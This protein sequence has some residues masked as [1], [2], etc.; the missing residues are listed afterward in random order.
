M[1][2]V[3]TPFSSTGVSEIFCTH[4]DAVRHVAEDRVLAIEA[5]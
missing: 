2:S 1:R 4:L 5:G 3:A